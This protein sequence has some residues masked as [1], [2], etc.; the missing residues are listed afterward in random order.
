M[1]NNTFEYFYKK[2]LCLRVEQVFQLVYD[3]GTPKG[4]GRFERGVGD[5]G[6]K[7]VAGEEG[8]GNQS[9][10]SV[11]YKDKGD[12]FEKSG[13]H[14][15]AEAF[16]DFVQVLFQLQLMDDSK[17]MSGVTV[18]FPNHE[19]R[20]ARVVDEC[21]VIGINDFTCPFAERE[22]FLQ[23]DV[24][25]LGNEGKDDAAKYGLEHF[26]LGAEIVMED[27]AVDAC[28]GS[29]VA[30]AGFREAFFN[31]QLLGVFYDFFFQ[32]FAVV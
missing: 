11:E 12:G 15:L 20:Q 6:R 23:D 8:H 13:G 4:E 3:V 22:V 29:D 7:Q 27:R 30:H 31:E 25:Y 2:K 17:K 5:G 32:I 9:V 21:L 16:T 1:R 10:E 24:L 14:F 19:H 18:N 28:P 26:V